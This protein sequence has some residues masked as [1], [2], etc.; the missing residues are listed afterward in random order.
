M[1]GTPSGLLLRYVGNPI[2]STIL[3]SSLHRMLSRCVLLI[4]VVGRRTGRRYT[5]PVGYVR[6]DGTLDVLVANRD[7]KAWWRNLET[8]APVE[9]VLDG[10][11][12]RGRAEALTFA[13]DPRSFM[14]AL[15]N[16]AARN[17]RGARAVGIRDVED[18]AGLRLASDN[19]AMVRISLPATRPATGDTSA[20]ERAWA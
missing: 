13:K 6:Q 12:I 19:V 14:G 4:M 7:K 10:Q 1:S 17:R 2:V 15:R 3:R 20:S 8:P 18:L 5:M 16:Y 9:L 11:V